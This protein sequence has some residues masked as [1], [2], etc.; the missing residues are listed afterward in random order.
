MIFLLLAVTAG[1][2]L[3]GEAYTRYATPEQKKEWE[4]FVKVHHGEAGAI[5]L[6]AGLVT[7][8][9]NLSALGM[10][11]MI[12]D[13]EDYKKWFTGDKRQVKLQR[14]TRSTRRRIIV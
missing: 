7:K 14:F 1:A 6:S 2:Y 9:P 11:L 3:L 4:N 10:G 13:R 8:S 5:I 12:H